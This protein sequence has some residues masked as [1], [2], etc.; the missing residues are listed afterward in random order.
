MNED[1]AFELC[2][3]MRQAGFVVVIW[4]P[5]EVENVVNKR[6]LRERIT[7]L[8]NEVISDMGE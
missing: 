5:E 3:K 6:H 1:D 8:G 4:T 2:E 7:E